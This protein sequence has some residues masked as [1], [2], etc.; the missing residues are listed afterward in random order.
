M[1]GLAYPRAVAR[2]NPHAQVDQRACAL[3]VAL[4]EEG[5]IDGPVVNAALACYFADLFPGPDVLL[6]GCT[7]FPVLEAAIRA[8]IPTDVS[9]VNSAATTAMVVAE[10]LQ[11]RGLRR[12]DNMPEGV[13]HYLVTD[14]L[15][16]FERTAAN[17]LGVAPAPATFEL[18]DLA[19]TTEKQ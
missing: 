8:A 16:R 19:L 3:L 1:R 17:F 5:W 11:R 10:D 12:A 18:V 13:V 4:A 7:H 15:A 14:N 6:L 9:V 2:L